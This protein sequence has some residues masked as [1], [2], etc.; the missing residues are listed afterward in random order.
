[1]PQSRLTLIAGAAHLPILENPKETIAELIRWL[2][3]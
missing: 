2:E 3:D 1:M